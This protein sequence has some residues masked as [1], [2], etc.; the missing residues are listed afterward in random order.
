MREREASETAT[1]EAPGP[2]RLESAGD[3]KALAS[4]LGNAAFGRHPRVRALTAARSRRLSRT[5]LG[6]AIHAAGG[7]PGW[8]PVFALLAG[9]TPAQTN[10][11]L[12]ALDT[13]DLI[14]LRANLSSA[15]AADRPRIST[16][17]DLLLLWSDADATAIRN[18]YTTSG[19]YTTTDT[20]NV[21]QTHD[22]AVWRARAVNALKNKPAA[23]KTAGN[24]WLAAHEAHEEWVLRGSTP[25]EP[26]APGALP[27]ALSAI[28][29]PP[30]PSM[31]K[32]HRYDIT[33]PGSTTAFS[34]RD[35]PVA[36]S[37]QY[38]IN[39]T[40]VG[41]AGTKLSNRTD[42]AAIFTA[43]GI[44]DATVIKV[45][46]KV[47]SHEGGLEAVNTYDTGYI[48]IGFIQFTSGQDGTGSL[49]SVLR[50]MKSSNATDFDT[51]FHSM[52][53]DVD[54]VGLTVVDPATGTIRRGSEA[55]RTV[56]DDKR[57]TAV[58]QRAGS[59]SRSFQA[60]QVVRAQAQYYHGPQSFTVTQGS[61]TITGT[62]GDVLT[63]EAGKTA[64]MDRAVQKG[65]GNARNKFEAACKAVITAHPTVT[66]LAQLAAYE[67]ESIPSLVNRIHVLSETDLTQPPA[68]PAAAST[69]APAAPAPVP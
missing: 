27:A 65:V 15:P 69:A 38:L 41:R 5:P 16:A 22:Y 32:I 8:A 11:L 50:E 62:Y 55:V 54:A 14:S 35:D 51:Y 13:A 30:T 34:Y 58:F 17:L 43:A 59:D 21:R 40:G 23:E 24:T 31:R 7:T 6:D 39:E 52:G 33:L 57:L 42:K 49:A 47:S 3:L 45:M 44:S 64:M 25:P 2:A 63:S 26:A 56:M 1:K 29:S 67:I 37:Y 46:T 53:I 9:K 61:V 28:G 18:R 12:R 48:S 19:T 66:T 10:A 60:A 20:G 36:P 4:K 68:A